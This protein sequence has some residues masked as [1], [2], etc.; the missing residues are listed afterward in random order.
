MT[1]QEKIKNLLKLWIA[2]DNGQN[3]YKYTGGFWEVL[4]PLMQKYAPEEL[5]EYESI[6][7]PFEY[8][9]PSVKKAVQ[10]GIEDTDFRNAITYMNS[11]L[12]CTTSQDVHLIDLGEDSIVPYLPNQNIDKQHYWGRE[13]E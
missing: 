3:L 4:Y 8:F 1:I 5:Q 11:R 7:G 6:V 9:D 10:S 2:T 12:T 13:E